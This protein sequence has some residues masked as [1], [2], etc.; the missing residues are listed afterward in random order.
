MNDVANLVFDLIASALR[1][2][3]GGP[4]GDTSNARQQHQ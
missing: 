3:H 1:R 2:R 4:S